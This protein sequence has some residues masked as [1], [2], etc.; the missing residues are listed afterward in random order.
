M[1]EKNQ[2][3]NHAPGKLDDIQPKKQR[4]THSEVANSTAE[5]IALIMID[6]EEIKDD[7]KKT[8]K[9]NDIKEIVLTAVKDLLENTKAEIL[10]KLEKS[11]KPVEQRIDVIESKLKK[12]ILKI[13]RSF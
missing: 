8:A 4:R 11:I 12:K 2:Y 9:T 13:T 3:G 6:L 7:L 5:D 10:E 1:S